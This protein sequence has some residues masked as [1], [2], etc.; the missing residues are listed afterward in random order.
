MLA[1]AGQPFEVVRSFRDIDGAAV[2]PSPAPTATV[3]L[4]G[5]PAA[6]ATVRSLAEPGLFGARVPAAMLSSL[7]Q[8]TVVWSW[9]DDGDAMTA[10]DVV[11]VTTVPVCTI[12]D[13]EA[14]PASESRIYP[15][16]RLMLY[17]ISVATSQFEVATN[18]TFSPR[19]A[20]DLVS[21]RYPKVRVPRPTTIVAISRDGV[22]IADLTGVSVDPDTGVIYGL[23]PAYQPATWEITVRYGMDRPPADVTR[24]VAILASSIAVAGPW[25]D[26]GVALLGDMPARMLTAGVGRTKFSIPEV[27][28]AARRYRVPTIA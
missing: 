9:S 14:L 20:T 11:D 15:A 25:D 22:P 3:S 1:A 21:A 17:A 28:A 12:S 2:D 10:E 4:N 6:T 5:A 13:I 19:Q 18:E 8:V 23:P 24:A 7:G 27:E 16:G 26:R